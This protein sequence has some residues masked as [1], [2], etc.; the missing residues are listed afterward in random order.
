MS[1][2]TNASR[3]CPRNLHRAGAGG[4]AVSSPRYWPVRI[5]ANRG[6]NIR[7]CLFAAITSMVLVMAAPGEERT[8]EDVLTLDRAIELARA[9]NRETKRARFDMDRQREA[10]A[11]AKT[12]Y[13]PRFDT[14]LL[15]TELLT[16]LDFTISAGQLG[17]FPST[18]P[19]PSSNVDLHTPTRPIAVASITVTQPITEI[20]R[21]RFHVAKQQL[22]EKLSRQAYSEQDQQLV[23][24]V[25][26]VYYSLL[27]SQ[28]Q[29]E[30]QRATI[31]SLEELGRLTERR[32]KERAALK[33]D[34][35]R[36][37][38][39]EAKARY[40]LL[41]LEDALCDRKEALNHL[42]GRDLLTAFTVQAVSSPLPE[43]A[44][45]QAARSLA[46]AQRPEVKI[47]FIKK[48][49]AHLETR[50]EKTR[51]LP[52]IS[53]QANYVT[54]AGINFLPKNIAAV[55]ALLT[56]QPWD[57]GQKRHN[58]AQKVIAEH[59]AA[60]TEEDARDQVLLDVDSQFRRLREARAQLAVVESARDAEQERLRNQTDAY[61]QEAILLSDLLQQQASFATAEDQYRQA[62]L[63]FW[64]ARADFERALGE[65]LAP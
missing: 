38:A 4:L 19:I 45:L 6:G 55:G 48:N 30:S 34:S 10:S 22:N 35:L 28:S 56:W 63:A 42:L 2:M 9:N 31:H 43:E 5:R 62:L 46:L 52:D 39:E 13:Y 59:E 23:S 8:S 12:S 36:I 11:E 18:G 54:P 57:W 25:R 29:A 32:L 58:V 47:A 41:V 27:Q 15:G 40:Q 61:S 16:P 65:E 24:N 7:T 21:I 60:L 3:N 17:T 53:I 64:T 50:I 33:T 44:D 14:Y 51:Y 1:R 49:Q 37:K 20:L 26:R